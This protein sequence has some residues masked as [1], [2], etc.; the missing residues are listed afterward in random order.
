MV[1]LS[2]VVWVRKTFEDA[3]FNPSYTLIAVARSSQ[4]ANTVEPLPVIWAAM[5][6]S[7]YALSFIVRIFFC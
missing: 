6:P 5:A 3:G 4:S 2:G 7:S 1:R